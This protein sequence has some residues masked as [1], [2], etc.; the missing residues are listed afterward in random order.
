MTALSSVNDEGRADRSLT[1]GWIFTPDLMAKKSYVADLP[2]SCSYGFWL[3][4]TTKD[5]ATTYNEVE[6]FADG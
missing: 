1:G 6:T 4:N 2:T 3:K 5:G